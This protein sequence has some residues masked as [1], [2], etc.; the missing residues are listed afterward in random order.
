MS[1]S[2]NDLNGHLFA[3]MDRLSQ[4]GLKGQ[5]LMDEVARAEAVV[6]VADQ[7]TQ[8]H[9]TAIT[10]AKLF[11]EHGKSVLPLLPQVGGAPAPK[12]AEEASE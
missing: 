5:D 12:S 10:A 2:I 3:A 4:G 6:A 9:R 7:I 8:N 1:G 11:A